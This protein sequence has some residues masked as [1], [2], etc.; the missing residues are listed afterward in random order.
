MMQGEI[1]RRRF[2][3]SAALLGVPLTHR[4][5]PP[6]SAAPTTAQLPATIPS[7]SP[8]WSVHLTEDF[9]RVRQLVS[10]HPALARASLGC[11]FGDWESPLGAAPHAG[12]RPL[13]YI[14]SVRQDREC[15]G[16]LGCA[17]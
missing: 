3:A 9:D 17:S 16:Q 7:E 2:L 12:R 13:P 1:E 11:G 5:G 8:Q 14:P 6:Q 10:E 15:D 4:L